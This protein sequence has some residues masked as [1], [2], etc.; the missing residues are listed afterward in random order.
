MPEKIGRQDSL[1]IGLCH[2]FPVLMT[3]V[4]QLLHERIR[5]SGPLPFAE[6]MSLALYHSEHGYYGAGPRR[7]GREGDFFTAVSVGPLFGKL[8]ARHAHSAWV[9]SG[10]PVDFT[11]IEQGA[12]DGQ[13]MEDVFAGLREMNSPLAQTARFLIVEPNEKY[14]KAQRQR[15]ESLL[16]NRLLWAG[17]V[18]DLSSITSA[19][20]FYCNELLDAFPVHLLRWDGEKW[21]EQCV[22]ANESDDALRWMSAPLTE[23]LQ[24]IADSLPRPSFAPHVVDVS[25]ATIQWTRDLCSALRSVTV[26]IADYGLDE[27]DFFSPDRAEGTIRR[28][29]RHQMDGRVLEN[30]GECDLTA[31]VNFTRV[32]QAAE[33]GGFRVVRYE[34]QGR[35]LTRLAAD[36]L[37]GIEGA[38]PDAETRSQLRQFQ[39]LTHPGQMG[40]KFC[41][42]L[43]ER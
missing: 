10:S 5:H 30:L 38:M 35:H 42:L 32:I 39:T 24:I 6:V 31:Q 26:F 12:H 19:T 15:L 22:G 33:A 40:A 16:Q 3:H 1:T 37:R 23:S 14:R 8:I 43:L 34:D 29:C 2:R 36:W 25:P 21:S 18:S 7:I 17:G 11:I 4:E 20:F 41:V 9:R 27:E 28:Y 13:L